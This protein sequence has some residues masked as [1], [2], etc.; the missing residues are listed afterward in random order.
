MR[1]YIGEDLT[2]AVSGIGSVRALA[3]VLGVEPK[4][5]AAQVLESLGWDGGVC[6]RPLQEKWVAT[7]GSEALAWHVL[8]AARERADEFFLFEDKLDRLL[9]SAA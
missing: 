1:S 4:E 2:G 9:E 8:N 7:G 6:P 3:G 5:A